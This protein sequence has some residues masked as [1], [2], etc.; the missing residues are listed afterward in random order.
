MEEKTGRTQAVFPFY[1]NHVFAQIRPSTR[2]CTDLGLALKK[3]P[4]RLID[5]VGSTKKD[6]IT[7]RIEITSC[8]T[9]MTR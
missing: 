7:H 6:R 9:L 2:T 8:W 5:T 1:R 4:G 3:T